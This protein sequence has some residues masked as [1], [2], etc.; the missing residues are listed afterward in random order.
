MTEQLVEVPTVLSYAT[1]QKRDAKQTI[2]IPVSRRR[3]GQG[4][5]QGSHPGQSS[6]AHV[7]EQVVD[8]PVR[9]GIPG[10]FPRQGSS[11]RT[12]EQL[13]DIP[14][15]GG[16]LHV[17][18]PDPGALASSAVS[19]D[20]LANPEGWEA[21]CFGRRGSDILASQRCSGNLFGKPL[22][23]DEPNEEPDVE[24]EE[25]DDAYDGNAQQKDEVEK[26]WLAVP[27]SKARPIPPMSPQRC[28]PAKS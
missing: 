14:V 3:R 19:P 16:G 7:V 28:W 6:T 15:P 27:C 10:F 23:E 4:G 22:D 17:P 9:G 2:D 18:L 24:E 25:E 13:V 5:L 11:Q 8:I 1:L 21:P 20:E 12:V 26:P